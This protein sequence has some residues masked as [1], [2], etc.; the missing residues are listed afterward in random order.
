MSGLTTAWVLPPKNITGLD[1]LAVR[2]V[3]EAIYTELVPCVTN[4]TD[5]VRNYAFYPWFT[6]TFS[7]RRPGASYDE[8]VRFFRR[9]ECLLTMTGARHEQ[10]TQEAPAL[11]GEGLPGR[12]A[13]LGPVQQLGG[14]T[15][16]LSQFAALRKEDSGSY[17]ATD[18]GGLEQYYLGT[19][20]TLDIMGRHGRATMKVSEGRGLRLA[21]LFDAG[22]PGELFWQTLEQ[23]EV[24]ITRLDALAPFCPCH[25]KARP[26]ERDAVTDVLLNRDL[27]SGM[28][29]MRDVFRLL[30][31]FLLKYNAIERDEKTLT[32]KFRESAYCGTL[33]GDGE[34]EEP[35]LTTW[36]AYQRH[37]LLSI[38]V[39]SLF[40]AVFRRIEE[41]DEQ[42]RLPELH[43]GAQ[44][45]DWF[46]SL[47]DLRLDG[48]SLDR[49]F[50]AHMEHT[51]L[52]LPP[53]T[54]SDSPDHELV[55]AR[56]ALP[57]E[58]VPRAAVLALRLLTVLALRLTDRPPYGSFQREEAY[59]RDYPINLLSLRTLARGRWSELTVREWVRWLI[60]H[61]CVG[62]QTRVALRKLHAQGLD[63]FR[64]R[65]TDQGLRPVQ[66][67]EVVYSSPRL[68]QAL[69]ALRDLGFV[70][71]DHHLTDRGRGLQV[72]LHD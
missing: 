50:P 6:W 51:A 22:V 58:D 5:R 61:W 10:H 26:E 25:L 46:L 11:H 60:T 53:I 2:A 14:E 47:A 33:P 69:G 23:D 43:S 16:S 68:R 30:S 20:Q 7:R 57:E 48:L 49:S 62:Q 15:L 9:A 38:G 64:L 45:A 18:L 1:H 35:A 41:A 12:R 71:D 13:L 34:W 40:W 8:Y 36:A 67:I 65:P 19:L 17:F 4:V 24:S 63:T 59:F 56:E 42:G 39:Q 54:A 32:Q 27:L 21:K 44:V 66:N 29:D 70:D 55:L 52:S 72:H 3:S 31:E 28:P 37:E